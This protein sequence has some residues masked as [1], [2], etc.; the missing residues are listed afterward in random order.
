MRLRASM[1]LVVLVI[2]APAVLAESK[3]ATSGEMTMLSAT[4]SSSRPQS[5]ETSKVYWDGNKSRVEMTIAGKQRIIIRDGS[6]MYMYLPSEKSARK[7]VLPKGAQRYD[8]PGSAK[9]ERERL[10]RDAK[11]VGREKVNGFDCDVYTSKRVMGPHTMDIKTWISRDPRFPAAVKTVTKTKN[12]THTTEVKNVKLG[13]KPS[14]S[15]FKLPKGTKVT[16]MKMPTG[17]P[18]GKMGTQNPHQGMKMPGSYQ[19]VKPLSPKK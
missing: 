14:A 16:E 5:K 12:A 11:K 18:H 7:S 3:A 15:I 2:L 19:G 10:T 17:N 4:T 13:S 9:M 1:L 8:I 6:T